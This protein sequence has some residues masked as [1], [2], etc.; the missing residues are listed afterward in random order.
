MRGHA[1]G[2]FIGW[3]RRMGRQAH[4]DGVWGGGKSCGAAQ[5]VGQQCSSPCG[6]WHWGRQPR[7]DSVGAVASPVA[8]A[9]LGGR[10]SPCTKA[11]LPLTE[12]HLETDPMKFKGLARPS[13]HYKPR[14]RSKVEHK[15]FGSGQNPPQAECLLN[16][17]S[18]ARVKRKQALLLLST[19]KSRQLL[20][21]IDR[22]TSLSRFRTAS[23]HKAKNTACSTAVH[24]TKRKP[25][26]WSHSTK[27]Q[28][29]QWHKNQ[30]Y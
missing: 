13:E 14:H 10:G 18:D 21:R 29:K 12:Q 16:T 26:G 24:T 20:H 4:G 5:S 19:L 1:R 2:D 30:T 8:R 9:S 25:A 15:P 3:S 17:C 7:G 23:Q 28:R 22:K 6:S 11:A 27:A